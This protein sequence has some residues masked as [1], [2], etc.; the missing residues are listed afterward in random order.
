MNQDNLEEYIN[1]ALSVM[2]FELDDCL[3]LDIDFCTKEE[4]SNLGG[5]GAINTLSRVLAHD[6]LIHM[7]EVGW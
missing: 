4:R 7:K 1:D 3:E 2:L 5:G 6:L